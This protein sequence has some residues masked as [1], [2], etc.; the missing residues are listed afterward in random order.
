MRLTSRSGGHAPS[1]LLGSV[2]HRLA[3]F[4]LASVTACLSIGSGH[5]QAKPR[6]DRVPNIV[7]ILADNN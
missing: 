5:C 2:P 7:L 3:A 4:V 1:E 6:P